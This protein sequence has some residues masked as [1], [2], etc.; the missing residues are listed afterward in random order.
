VTPFCTL[1]R[2]Q[3]EPAIVYKIVLLILIANSQPKMSAVI[4]YVA[5]LTDLPG[6]KEKD[7]V[8]F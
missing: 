5:L 7:E 4:N 6:T 1:F 8:V 3:E 2:E